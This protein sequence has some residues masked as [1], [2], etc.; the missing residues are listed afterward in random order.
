MLKNRYILCE[1]VFSGFC[2]E[3]IYFGE[4]SRVIE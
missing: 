2:A 1:K 3:K 4:F